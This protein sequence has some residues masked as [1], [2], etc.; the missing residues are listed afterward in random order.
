MTYKVGS[1][2]P[3]HTDTLRTPTRSASPEAFKCNK[4]LVL[5]INIVDKYTGGVFIH[6][7][8]RCAKLFAG[9]AVLFD[10]MIPHE[11]TYITSGE[12]I[13]LLISV[14]LLQKTE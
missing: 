11:V 9:D 5:S 7:G 14:H 4:H 8:K 3:T 13:A 1:S 6:N 2:L 12:R 10:G